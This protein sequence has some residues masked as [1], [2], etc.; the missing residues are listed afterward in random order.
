MVSGQNTQISTGNKFLLRAT[1]Q[2][3]LFV[4]KLGMKLIAASGKITIQAQ[5]DN[6]EITAAKLFD[7]TGLEEIIIQAPKITWISQDTQTVM[8]G[9]NVTTQCMGAHTEH[10]GKHVRTGPAGSSLVLPHLPTSVLEDKD[11]FSVRADASQIFDSPDEAQGTPYI[12]KR[13]DGALSE[14]ILD[15]YG[16]TARIYSDKPEDVT[17]LIGDGEWEIH[18]GLEYD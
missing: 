16:R 18:E 3:S 7:M 10:A 11:F 4:H 9:G 1:E 13:A 2:I 6:V 14:G 8:G 15:S 12:L 17:V 5:N